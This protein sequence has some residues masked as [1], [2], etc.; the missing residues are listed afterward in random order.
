MNAYDAIN[1]LCTA[2][3]ERKQ[4]MAALSSIYSMESAILSARSMLRQYDTEAHPDDSRERSRER[5][6]A[7]A[8]LNALASAP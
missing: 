4:T 7:V 3:A 8:V 5:S 1:T 6:L 2:D